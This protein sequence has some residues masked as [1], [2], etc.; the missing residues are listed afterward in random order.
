MNN[1]KMKNVL[2]NEQG[3]GLVL[4]LMVLLVLSVL[5]SAL[6]MVTINSHRLADHTQDTN[7]AYYIAE[8]GANMAYEEFKAGILSAYDISSTEDDFFTSGDG[9]KNTQVAINVSDDYGVNVFQKIGDIQPTANVSVEGPFG[10]GNERTYTIKSTGAIAGK[11][12]VVEKPVV[13]TWIPKKTEEPPY[14]FPFGPAAITYNKIEYM[15]N[16][17]YVDGM[18]NKNDKAESFRNL[19]QENGVINNITSASW[20]NFKTDFQS[21]FN[22]AVND[23]LAKYDLSKATKHEPYSDGAVITK[24]IIAQSGDLTFNGRAQINGNLINNGS[25]LNFNGETKI[26]NGDVIANRGRINFNNKIE[27]NGDI[28]ALGGTINFGSQ[29]I[30]NGSIIVDTNEDLNLKSNMIING[31]VINTRGKINFDPNNVT[32]NGAVISP[33]SQVSLKKAR[34]IGTVIAN[35]VGN[36]SDSRLKYSNN[37]LTHFPFYQKTET[38]TEN[39]QVPGE[40]VNSELGTIELIVPKPALEP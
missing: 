17:I 3:S 40:G 11:K 4:A 7:S 22:K 15:N 12:R 33:N 6:G 9:V 10:T 38:G 8:A 23:K 34:V 19:T 37:Y 27:I 21:Q 13:V 30:V 25:N 29:T 5:G 32:I 36:D 24:D 39:E 31:N 35:Q 20:A 14:P 2:V 1:K 28:I 18:I 16:T 26:I